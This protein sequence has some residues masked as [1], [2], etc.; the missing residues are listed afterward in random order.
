MADLYELAGLSDEVDRDVFNLT[1]Y[2][3]LLRPFNLEVLKKLS[4]SGGS[5]RDRVDALYQYVIEEREVLQNTLR[6]LPNKDED[7]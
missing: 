1:T 6:Y 2:R 7:G 3:D 4:Q 5:A